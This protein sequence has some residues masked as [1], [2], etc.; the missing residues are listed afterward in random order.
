M[1]A[2]VRGAYC[3]LAMLVPHLNW[4]DRCVT[5]LREYGPLTAIALVVPGGSLI[6]LG[7]WA[8]RHWRRVIQ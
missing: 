8:F 2:S 3:S 1:V 4:K 5:L 7:A 6:L